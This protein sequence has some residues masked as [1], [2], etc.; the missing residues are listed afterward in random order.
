MI[1]ILI[2]FLLASNAFAF[3]QQETQSMMTLATKADWSC[4]QTTALACPTPNP[5]YV[6]VWWRYYEPSLFIETVKAPGDYVI[7]ESGA[8]I[9]PLLSR[10]LASSTSSSSR[11]G[12]NGSNLQFNEVHIFDFP[13][14][15]FI[16]AAMCPDNSEGNFQLRYLSEIDSQRWRKGGFE[17]LLPGNI[18]LWGPLYPRVGFLTHFSSMVASA[19]TSIRAVDISGFPQGHLVTSP[20]RFQPNYI[21]DRLQM[22]FPYSGK[23]FPLGEN[24]QFMDDLTSQDGRYV[25]I[26]WH[27]RECCRTVSG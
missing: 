26:Y 20:F 1:R 7:A 14:K 19:L 21:K 4:M 8:I 12:L 24:L 5:P 13:F 27:Y 9:K 23:C 10:L 3:N 6:G 17:V 15:A 25:W 18:G 16:E 22:S 11:G 2:F